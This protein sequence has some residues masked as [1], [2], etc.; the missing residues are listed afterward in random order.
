M[1]RI[2]RAWLVPVSEEQ[3]LHPAILDARVATV[4][5]KAVLEDL[6]DDQK[7]RRVH[8]F[9]VSSF[10]GNSSP[11]SE[12]RKVLAGYDPVHTPDN[13]MAGL[14]NHLRVGWEIRDDGTLWSLVQ[15]DLGPSTASNPR[16]RHN[17]PKRM[18]LG[19]NLLA[20]AVSLVGSAD[21]PL[22]HQSLMVKFSAFGGLTHEDAIVVSETAAEQLAQHERYTSRVEIPRICTRIEHG[23]STAVAHSRAI[24]AWIDL[25]AL[26]GQ[27]DDSA[28]GWVEVDLPGSELPFGGELEITPIQSNLL[29]PELRCAFDISVTRRRPLE[30][31]DKLS[32]MHG[33]KGVVSAIRAPS[34]LGGADILLSPLGTARR[35]AMGQFL[36][37]AGGSWDGET[38]PSGEIQVMRQPQHARDKIAWAGTERGARGQ[39]YGQMEFWALMAHGAHAIAKELLSAPRSHA[40]WADE[41]RALAGDGAEGYPLAAR[42]AV[43]R[44]LAA[45]G[46][47]LRGGRFVRIDAHWRSRPIAY[48][49]RRA[50]LES[51]EFFRNAIENGEQV[52]IA[53]EKGRDLLA[54]VPPWLRP[55]SPDT[56]HPL[57]RGYLLL[58][59]VLND[60]I[61][62]ATEERIKGFVEYCQWLSVDK[63]GLGHF[64][65]REVL[66][67]R[68]NRSARAVVIPDPGLKID[69]VRLPKAVFDALLDY[70]SHS[71]T[72][73]PGGLGGQRVLVHRSPVLHRYGL[74][75][76]RPIRRVDD[77]S[78]IGLPLGILGALGADFDGDQ[79]CVVALTTPDATREAEEKLVP[80]VDGLKRD[81]FRVERAAF[82]LQNELSNPGE[83]WKLC[84]ETGSYPE[85]H[86]G[87]VEIALKGLEDGW[88]QTVLEQIKAHSELR[89]GMTPKDWLEQ[90]EVEMQDVRD[91]VARKGR[92]GGVFRRE[93]YRLQ[94]RPSGTA[95]FQRAVAALQSVTERLAQASLKVKGDKSEGLSTRIE[96]LEVVVERINRS[97]KGSPD[98]LNA[99]AIKDGIGERY[100]SPER[101]PPILQWLA[102][103]SRKTLDAMTVGH[104]DLDLA[105][106]AGDP[107]IDWFFGTED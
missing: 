73:K 31:G 99:Q 76:L 91:S 82:R 47:K 93:F 80:G 9:F 36:D 51:V 101:R 16:Y 59:R 44:F 20:R 100:P 95:E 77:A 103:P 28:D 56:V 54:V 26:G 102:N 72:F 45:V 17:K 67:R 64:L 106:T 60:R 90:A 39:R 68:L 40:W 33:I 14:T 107:R 98:V 11:P 27:S 87:F 69:E 88:N 89:V 8:R 52:T 19:A 23:E 104:V 42:A 55:S 50:Q 12:L 13:E 48:K 21:Q 24:R 85:K 30:L 63:R 65:E 3:C 70:D 53:D 22:C 15:S 83:E 5:V 84:N 71:T 75:A 62:G 1:Q 41:E 94:Y 10:G 7:Q 58:L 81:P 86:R 92:L 18:M 43:N 61:L 96:D 4:R 29:S 105:T 34:D 57:T 25:Y 38:A 35:G 37:A 74:L 97:A 2:L 78:V 6:P 46:L 79:V 32:T 49:D 66:G